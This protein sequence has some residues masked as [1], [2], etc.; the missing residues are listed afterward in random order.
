MQGQIAIALRESRSGNTGGFIWNGRNRL[1]LQ[2]HGDLPLVDSR[3]SL[4]SSPQTTGHKPPRQLARANSPPVSEMR[5]VLVSSPSV[6]FAF[7]IN[8]S[9]FRAEAPG[10]SQAARPPSE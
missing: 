5:E 1:R 3:C 2:R 9:Q 10:L 8:A 7:G 6:A 4:E